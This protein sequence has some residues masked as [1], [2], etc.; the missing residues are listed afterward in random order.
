[1][2]LETNS[3]RRVGGWREGA[4]SRTRDR[5]NVRTEGCVQMKPVTPAIRMVKRHKCRAPVAV[6]LH[7][8]S[9]INSQPKKI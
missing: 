5:F 9:L 4:R 8:F 7:R 1:M 2:Q 6:Q 3:E